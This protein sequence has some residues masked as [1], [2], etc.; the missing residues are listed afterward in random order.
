MEYLGEIFSLMIFTIFALNLKS[1]TRMD[2]GFPRREYQ[3]KGG[4]Y[5]TIHSSS[6][7][8][9]AVA[10]TRCHLPDMRHNPPQ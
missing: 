1:F 9:A 10:T 5:H 7:S 4:K 6:V 3:P 8:T 2:P